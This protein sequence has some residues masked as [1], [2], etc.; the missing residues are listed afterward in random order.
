MRPSLWNRPKNSRRGQQGKLAP[1]FIAQA[2]SPTAPHF[3]EIWWNPGGTLVEPYLRATPD[4]P[5]AYLG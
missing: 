4:Y 3:S 5:E 2:I 1:P